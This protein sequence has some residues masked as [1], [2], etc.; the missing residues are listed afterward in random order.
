MSN[1]MHMFE[2]VAT[3]FVMMMSY[4]HHSSTHREPPPREEPYVVHM[5]EGVEALRRSM[6]RA[7]RASGMED[8]F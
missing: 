1:T 6:E 2:A 5:Q 4:Y 8:E 7:R 3:A